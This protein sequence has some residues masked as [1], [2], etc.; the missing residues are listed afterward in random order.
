MLFQAK[1]EIEDKFELGKWQKVAGIIESRTGN[2]YPAAAVQKKFKD[3]SK[4]NG[5]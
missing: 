5:V 1:K 4:G 2:K 3:A